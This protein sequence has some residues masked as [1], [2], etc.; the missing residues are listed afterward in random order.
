MAVAQVAPG[1]VEKAVHGLHQPRWQQ[2]FEVFFGQLQ[3]Q[4]FLGSQLGH[5]QALGALAPAV[6]VGFA[7]VVAL[8]VE[9]LAQGFDLALDGAQVALKTCALQLLVQLSRGDLAPARYAAQ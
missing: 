7:A 6:T 2:V 9:M 5:G 1:L 8:D 4:R 3:Q